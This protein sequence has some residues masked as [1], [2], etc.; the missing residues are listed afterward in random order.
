MNAE[1]K[2]DESKLLAGDRRTL[3]RAIT[4]VESL[5][6]EDRR[7]AHALLE[8]ILPY[9]GKSLRIGI[10][11][12]P[13]VGKS[14]FIESFGLASVA[15]GKKVAV[16]TVDPSSPVAGGSIL[17]D[18][19]RMER[20]AGDSN[21]YIRPSPSA[22]AYG[23]VSHS[24]RE[25]IL[26]CEAAGYDLILLETVGVGQSEFDA[27]GMVDFFLVMIPPNAGDE[28]QGLKK[29]IMELVD[30]LVVNKADSGNETAALETVA[31]YRSAL[32][33][34]RSA[35]S[36]E[37]KVVSCSSLDGTGIE[38]IRVLIG[39]Y[40]EQ[41]RATGD[42]ESR[43]EQQRVSWLRKL[44]LDA[45]TR[46]LHRN[47]EVARRIASIEQRV[48]SGKVTP[49]SAADQIIEWFESGQ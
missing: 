26:L 30:A 28:L 12:P 14:T 32:N 3:A 42:F 47:S 37:P 31:A 45:L 19:T 6:T 38:E 15:T 48:V 4:L 22:G 11:G 7:S 17:G 27:A 35:K 39:A 29:G 13:G 2:I 36:W 34:I 25:S 18:K 20:L 9:T 46:Q 40:E 43:R 1:R 10:S 24:T 23:G 41:M 5:R 44:T 21:A 16:L 8:N 33:L 49:I